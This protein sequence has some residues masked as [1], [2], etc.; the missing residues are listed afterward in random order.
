MRKD[1]AAS[2][3][4]QRIQIETTD[5][6][7]E[8]ERRARETAVKLPKLSVAPFKGTPR[9]WIRFSNQFMAQVDN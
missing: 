1:R 7:I 2:K 3:E 5:R 8:I 4:Q 9:D 6:E